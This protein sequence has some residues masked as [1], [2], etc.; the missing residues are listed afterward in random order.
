MSEYPPF[1]RVAF[2]IP[3]SAV[4]WYRNNEKEPAHPGFRVSAQLGRRSLIGYVVE[5]AQA[6]PLE[7]DKLKSIARTVDSESLFGPSTLDL[8]EWLSSMY[9]CS[10]GEALG[11]MLPSGKRE[12]V[13]P[14]TEIND[15]EIEDHPLSLSDEQATAL[16][17]IVSQPS[18]TTYLYGRTGTGKT[19]VFLQAAERTLNEGR[20]VIYLV[21][22]IALTG[23]VVRA[24]RMRFGAACAVIHSRLTPSEKLAEW[25]RIQSGEARMIIGVRSAIFAP[26]SNLGL[27]VIDEEHEGSYKA[28]NAPRYHARQVGMFRAS[29]E[30]ARLVLGS[31]TPSVEAWHACVHGDMRLAKLFGRQGGGGFP[32]VELID[33]RREPSAISS[34]LADVLRETKANGR[35]SILFLNRRGFSHFF[36]CN[37]C[38]AE[39]QC[40]HCSVSLTYH[41]EQNQLV[42]HYCGYRTSPP[43]ACPECGSLDIGWK[44]FGTERVEE[45]LEAKFPDWHIA[46]LDA[47]T[48]TKRGSLEK[49]LDDFRTGKYDVLLGTQMVAKGLNFPGV[50]TV[51]VVMADAGLNLPDFRASE[52]VFSLIVQV[53]GRAGRSDQEGRVFIQTFRPDNPVIR[54][55]AARDVE[56]FYARELTMRQAQ[57]FPPFSRI[58]RIVLRSRDKA[59]AQV[60]ARQLAARA[61]QVLPSGVELLGP[62]ECPLGMIASSYRWQILL[63]AGSLTLVHNSTQA[64]LRDFRPQSGVHTEVDIDPVQLL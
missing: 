7:S 56:S 31:A 45:E 63:R 37:T 51:G 32:S 39:L 35:Q 50:Q 48:I 33:M 14:S 64:L 36:S 58:A 61:A 54:L 46:R 30:K 60:A 38:G 28:G 24:A 41:K 13:Q 29:H 15:F 2:P 59:Q 49:T 34:R 10:L 44:G 52:R 23:Q 26:T 42:C 16:R 21:P 17:A 4:Y 47:D 19:E 8:A 22:E 43:D 55:A 53:S 25:R 11:V 18:G 1:V 12:S 6:C 57:D 62:A 9:F 27:I 5:E 3:V 40:K 20:S